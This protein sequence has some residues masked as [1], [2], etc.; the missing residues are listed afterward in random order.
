MR[1]E[2]ESV[3]VEYVKIEEMSR[4]WVEEEVVIGARRG[5]VRRGVRRVQGAHRGR[6]Q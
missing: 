3:E 4:P 1:I 2:V 5:R 6:G